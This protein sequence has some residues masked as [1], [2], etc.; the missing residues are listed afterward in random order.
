MSSECKH[1]WPLYLFRQWIYSSQLSINIL[2]EALCWYFKL[3]FYDSPMKMITHWQ[4]QQWIN[5]ERHFMRLVVLNG[6]TLSGPPAET[7]TQKDSLLCAVR[8]I[9]WWCRSVVE[10]EQRRQS[11]AGDSDNQWHWLS[12]TE[13]KR[14]GAGGAAGGLR[15]AE[16]EHKEDNQLMWAG[17]YINWCHRNRWTKFDLCCLSWTNTNV[18]LCDHP[19]LIL[20]IH[21]LWLLKL[22]RPILITWTHFGLPTFHGNTAVLFKGP[23]VNKTLSSFLS[24]PRIGNRFWTWY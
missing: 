17:L 22:W 7:Q 19:L 16:G 21:Q 11:R 12:Q 10:T 6:G 14:G 5:C 4:W 15:L 18:T 24:I 8:C 2:S 9:C 13:H 20:L 3:I 23:T 1:S